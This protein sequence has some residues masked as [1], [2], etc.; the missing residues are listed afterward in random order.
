[1]APFEWLP[2]VFHVIVCVTLYF[3]S[4]S[5]CDGLVH[6]GIIIDF[7][8]PLSCSMTSGKSGLWCDANLSCLRISTPQ[9]PWSP[10][11]EL[12]TCW[13]L[14]MDSRTLYLPASGSAAPSTIHRHGH[15]F[16]PKCQSDTDN[17]CWAFHPYFLPWVYPQSSFVL[18][19]WSL[20]PSDFCF[21]RCFTL[22]S[23]CIPTTF[24]VFSRFFPRHFFFS[25]PV[26]PCTRCQCGIWEHGL[27]NTGSFIPPWNCVLNWLDSV[28]NGWLWRHICWRLIGFLLCRR[29]QIQNPLLRWKNGPHLLFVVFFFLLNLMDSCQCQDC[30][31]HCFM[32]VCES[33]RETCLLFFTDGWDFFSLGHQTKLRPVLSL[34]MSKK[35]GKETRCPVDIWHFLFPCHTLFFICLLPY[36]Y[37][38]YLI[39]RP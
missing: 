2:F 34:A 17:P 22:F 3:Q 30:C 10:T 39:I 29:E 18:H 13:P 5:I 33:N 12:K 27:L 16:L 38:Q 9:K 19:S 1:M 26:A 4:S 36:V 8:L 20:P 15:P 14:T 24:C 7:V 25:L 6:K 37:Q 11:A 35:D 32:F 28:G 21:L 31:V 23:E